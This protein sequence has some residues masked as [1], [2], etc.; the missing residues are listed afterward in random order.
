MTSARGRRRP[1]VASVARGVAL[2]AGL[3]AAGVARRWFDV[4]EV[5]GGSMAPTLAAGDW[6]LI[7]RRSY[8][9]RLPRVGEV[10]LAADPRDPSREL[11][12]RV[13]SVD[14]AA[15]TVELRGDAPEAST[16]SRAFG[17]VPMDTVRW[18]AVLRYW[19]VARRGL[20]PER[21]GERPLDQAVD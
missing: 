21:P 10:V 12:K 16:D 8:E 3:A 17:A 15:G 6:L 2:G 11:I 19:P 7:E 14:A 1:L 9:G 4:V 18:R 13:A 5:Q 20:I